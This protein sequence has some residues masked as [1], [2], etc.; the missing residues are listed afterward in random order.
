MRT[1]TSDDCGSKVLRSSLVL[2]AASL[3]REGRCFTTAA[4][5]SKTEG[6]TRLSA[7]LGLTVGSNLPE[8]SSD[9]AGRL[10][11]MVRSGQVRSGQGSYSAEV[12]DHEGHAKINVRERA[13]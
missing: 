7:M 1:L 13:E 5:S 10:F 9:G 2:T 6:R 11:G 8:V 3:V 4:V 12:E